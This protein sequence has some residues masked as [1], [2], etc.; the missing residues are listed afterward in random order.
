[1]TTVLVVEDE[2]IIR[3]GACLMVED[4][5]FIA[6]EASGADQAI[7]ILGAR[8][9]IRLLLTDVDMPGSMDGLKL[10]HYVGS[11]WPEI[12]IIVASGKAILAQSELPR[13]ATFFAKP[14]AIVS[15]R[16]RFRTC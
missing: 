15:W 8:P 1:M 7:E 16:E 6:L 14:Y 9:D 10:S 4:A 2:A 12:K 13:G 3:M 11:R 5:G